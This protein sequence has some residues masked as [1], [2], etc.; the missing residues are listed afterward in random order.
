MMIEKI[1]ELRLNN[2]SKILQNRF[3]LQKHDSL[4][5]I[6]LFGIIS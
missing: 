2:M 5:K 3:E 6:K 1:E 4:S